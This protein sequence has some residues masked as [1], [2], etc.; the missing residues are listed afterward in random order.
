MKNQCC[1][2]GYDELIFASKMNLPDEFEIISAMELMASG[3]A[4]SNFDPIPTL[5]DL[6]KQREAKRILK[7]SV[8]PFKNTALH[9]YEKKELNESQL[10]DIVEKV[11]KTT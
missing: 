4:G 6:I 9:C 3:A 8:E 5:N 2:Y 10:W 7:Q 11:V 1:Y